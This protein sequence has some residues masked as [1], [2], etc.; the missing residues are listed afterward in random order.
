MIMK[1]VAALRA[2]PGKAWAGSRRAEPAAADIPAKSG[3]YDTAMRHSRRVRFLRKAIPV[4]CV[5]AVIGPIAWG[6]VAPFARSVS[7]IKIGPI[8]VSGSKVTMESPKLSGFKKDNKAYEVTAFQAIQDLKQPSVVELNKLTARLEQ[9]DKK[10]ARLTSDWG[11]LDQTAD[12]LDLKGNVRLRTDT[13]YEADMLSAR[14]SMKSGDVSSTEPVT[15]RS[16][17]GTISADSVEVRDNGKHAI[18]EGRVRSI[19]IPQDEPA[20]GEAKTP[21]EL[22]NTTQ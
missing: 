3:T 21:V 18:F 7:D 14:V 8:S 9:D 5:A 1:L 22:R 17:T 10:F 4:T 12:R 11:R 13:G 19:L 15:V 20:S 16:L 6:I 2:L